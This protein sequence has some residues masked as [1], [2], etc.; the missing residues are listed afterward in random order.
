MCD[1]CCIAH[2][3]SHPADATQGED[4]LPARGM[5]LPGNFKLPGGAAAS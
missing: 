2:L 3:E 5:H 1:A 4:A